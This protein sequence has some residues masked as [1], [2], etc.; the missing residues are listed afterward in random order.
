MDNVI[1]ML[2]HINMG[3]WIGHDSISRSNRPFFLIRIQ[4]DHANC[5]ELKGA[6]QSA[7][8]IIIST[9]YTPSSKDTSILSSEKWVE[10]LYYFQDY[11]AFL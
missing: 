8:D 5:P 6:D 11:A 7:L 3:A 1:S 4:N 9:H 2:C 10:A